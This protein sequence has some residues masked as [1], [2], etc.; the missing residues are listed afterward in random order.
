MSLAHKLN[1]I[2]LEIIHFA[3]G[4]DEWLEWRKHGVGGSD[5]PTVVGVDQYKTP[6]RLWLEKTGRIQPD[7][8]SR[9]PNVQRGKLYEPFVRKQ[10]AA[11]LG[12][13][14]AEYCAE[15]KAKR[16]RKVSFDGVTPDGVP[17]EIKCPCESGF[18][19]LIADPFNSKLFSLYQW[20]LQYQIAML[21]ADYGWLIFYS[22]IQNQIVP[23]KVLR[24]DEMIQLIFEKQQ[25]FY[26]AVENDTA[27]PKDP[28]RDEYTPTPE[29]EIEWGKLAV[30]LLNAQESESKLKAELKVVSGERVKVC[31]Q[32]MNMSGNFTS[33]AVQGLKVTQVK[34]RGKFDVDAYLAAKGLPAITDEERD[35]FSTEDTFYFRVSVAN[36]PYV[37][38]LHNIAQC[39]RM[40]KIREQMARVMLSNNMI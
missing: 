33:A 34:R 17:V 8:L 24:D 23:L 20:Q 5:I 18:A 25:E 27:P 35:Q 13:D 38:E 7:D 11:T 32:I 10:F 2:E 28:E 40:N 19:E 37:K 22:A 9:N 21:N 39:E 31:N 1:P 14:I 30:Q 15:D 26:L 6:Y 36:K 4:S 16:Y 3:Q 12:V 29:Q